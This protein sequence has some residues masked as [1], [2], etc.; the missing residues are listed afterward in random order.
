MRE[1]IID[2]HVHPFVEEKENVCFYKQS[3][4][5]ENDQFVKDL[6]KSGI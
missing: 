6:K 1:K 5:F 2:F 3:L 4:S